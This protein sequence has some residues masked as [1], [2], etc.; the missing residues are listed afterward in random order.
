MTVFEC[1]DH[2]PADSSAQEL[3]NCSEGNRK[4]A[5]AHLS[6]EI[7]VQKSARAKF[8]LPAL[9]VKGNAARMEETVWQTWTSAPPAILPEPCTVDPMGRQS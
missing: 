6:I 3:R 5:P 7:A 4:M 9:R 2:G 8:L 1:D